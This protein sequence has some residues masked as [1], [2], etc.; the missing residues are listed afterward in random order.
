MAVYIP[1]MTNAAAQTAYDIARSSIIPPIRR[2]NAN[3][4]DANTGNSDPNKPGF[5]DE[6]NPNISHPS[7]DVG[8][9]PAG[10]AN[11]NDQ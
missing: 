1:S 7:K 9:G 10:K 5:K 11:K 8:A 2:G 3:P 6:N 4:P